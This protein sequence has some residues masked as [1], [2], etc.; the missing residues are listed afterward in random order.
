MPVLQKTSIRFF[1]RLPTAVHFGKM[2]IT[3]Y[4]YIDAMNV[5]REEITTT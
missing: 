2:Y 5:G 3:C 4:I 1:K